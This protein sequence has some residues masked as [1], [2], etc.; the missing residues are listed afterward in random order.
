[1]TEKLTISLSHYVALKARMTYE[2]RSCIPLASWIFMSEEDRA[3]EEAMIAHLVTERLDQ[4]YE[5]D[6]SLK[7]IRPTPPPVIL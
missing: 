5:V 1:M 2:A 3:K 4:N 6:L 7:S